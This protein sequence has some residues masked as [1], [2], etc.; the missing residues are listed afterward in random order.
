ME[1]F[2]RSLLKYGAFDEYHSYFPDDFFADPGFAGPGACPVMEG[3]L[4]CRRLRALFEELRP[5]YAVLHNETIQADKAILLRGLLS[6]RELPMTFQTYTV[7]T[8]AHL[9]E[10]LDLCLLGDGM[11]PYDSIIVSSSSVRSVLRSYFDSLAEYTAGRVAYRG[12]VDI[13][14]YGL[15]PELFPERDKAG[16][17]RSLGIPE[18]AAVL[19]SLAR[20]NA[21][22]KM[23]YRRVLEYFG[24]VV[25]EIKGNVV[26]VLAGSAGAEDEQIIR[27]QARRLGLDDRIFLMANFEDRAKSLILGSGDVFISLSD[28]L[29]ES[30]GISL[31]EAMVCS[32]PVVC[33]DWDGSK[34]LVRDGENGFRIPVLWTAPDRDEFVLGN[35]AHPYSHDVMNRVTVGLQVDEGAFVRRVIEL[36]RDSGLRERMGRAGRESVLNSFTMPVVIR[37]YEDLWKELG[38]QAASDK[39]EYRDLGP[40]LRYN[41]SRD[42]NSY[43]T[44]FSGPKSPKEE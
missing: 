10:F 39:R 17:R 8:N 13:V 42:F 30:F 23:N 34:D 22:S 21:A 33:T 1:T 6:P 14:P 3:K 40:L 26:L 36:L 24:A 18:D 28:N 20:L 31:L 19:V 12:R 15:E 29:Q 32:L 4:K 37:R 5:D 43:P 16:C 25:R 7:A 38:A 9:R 11:R 2:A 41:Y 44:G 27:D 35:F